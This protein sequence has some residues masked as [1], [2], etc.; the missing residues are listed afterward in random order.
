MDEN[1]NKEKIKGS[2][3]P[4]GWFC[5]IIGMVLMFFSLKTIIF[6]GP[7]FFTSFVI[8]IIVLAKGKIA[9]GVL[10]LLSTIIIPIVCWFGLFA[11]NFGEALVEQEKQKKESLSKIEFEDMKGYEDGNYMY[12]EGKIRNKGN[13]TVDYVKVGVEWLTKDGTILDTDWTYAVSGEGLRPGA[14][15]SFKIMTP[16]D[17]RMQKY[18]YYVMND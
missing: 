3:A 13:T 2:L 9:N 8:S 1:L 12:C 14:A 16:R 18:R 7:L 5:F 4:V 6:Y 10:L 17:N 11:F 15:K